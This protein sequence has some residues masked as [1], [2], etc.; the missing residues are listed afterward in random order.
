M[1]V[2][3]DFRQKAALE[4]LADQL[5]GK[6]YKFGAEVKMTCLPKDIVEIDCS[7]LVEYLYYQIKIKI[8]DGSQNQYLVSKEIADFEMDTGDLVFKRDI[9]LL[10]VNHVG[11]ILKTTPLLYNVVEA[12]GWHGKVIMRPFSMFKKEKGKSEYCGV[13]RL[14]KDKVSLV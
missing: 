1:F 9:K 12:S 7:E 2:E 8:P 11:M 13:R 14:I 5:L 6:T 4:K 3:L 10:R